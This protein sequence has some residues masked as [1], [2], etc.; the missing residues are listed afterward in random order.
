MIND[1]IDFED[2]LVSAFEQD[3][4]G[5]FEYWSPGE[6]YTYMKE[7]GA[8]VSS[9]DRDIANNTE[10]FTATDLSDWSDYKIRFSEFMD[11]H[12]SW[13]DRLSIGTLRSAER[14]ARELREFQSRFA[15][16]C[17]KKPSAGLVEIPKEEYDRNVRGLGT[18]I[19]TLAAIAV[20]GFLLIKFLD[21]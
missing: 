21:R 17:K 7:V 2:E 9:L 20:G 4:L 6:M 16:A 18:T 13:W 5:F 1:V 12:D 15:A 19:T 8:K 10:C 11:G 3:E 14:F